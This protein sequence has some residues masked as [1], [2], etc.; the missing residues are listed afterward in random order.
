MFVSFI[1]VLVPLFTEL[2]NESETNEQ[3][4]E[5]FSCS[6]FVYM[7]SKSSAHNISIDSQHKGGKDCL[8]ALN[9]TDMQVLDFTLEPDTRT[10]SQN[11]AEQLVYF[12]FLL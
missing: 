2:Q 9:P 12:V 5:S 11:M 4:K 7:D 10:V 1:S 8:F 6:E 3:G